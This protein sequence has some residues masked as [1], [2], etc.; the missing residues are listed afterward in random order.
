MGNNFEAATLSIRKWVSLSAFIGFFAFLLYLYFFTDLGEVA[1]VISGANIFI[2]ALAFIA[3]LGSVVFNSLTWYSLLGNFSIK[4]GFWRVF[5]LGWV[6]IFVDALVPGGWSGDVFKGYLLVK[7]THVDT[8]RTAASI[9]IKNIL[10]LAVTL[11]ALISGL[12]FLFLNYS[13]DV[14]V[15]ASFGTIMILLALPLIIIIFLSVHLGA[16]KRLIVFLRRTFFSA[17][18]RRGN[19]DSF[20]AKLEKALTDY[21]DGFRTM[22]TNPKSLFSPIVFQIMAWAFDILTLFLIF[23]SIGY[24]AFPDKIIIVNSI[25]GNLQVQGF[26]FAGFT[27]IVSSSLY[28]VLGISSTLSSASVLLAGFAVFWFR[29]AVSFFAFQ[30]VIFSK[31]IPF[32][33]VRCRGMG[34][35]SCDVEGNVNKGKK[36]TPS[37]EA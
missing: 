8:G 20:D 27:Q 19:E 10:E 22:K 21:H 2:Y 18:R 7:D 32:L 34:K 12:V 24:F 23:Y 36:D 25:V 30:C 31:C 14:W 33:S 3:V 6:G 1:L 5:V 35:K 9:V 28:A 17:K 16:T 26:A 15:L 29:L 37:I 13:L 11:G 4:P